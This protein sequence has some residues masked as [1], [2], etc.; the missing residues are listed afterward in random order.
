M[1]ATEAILVIALCLAVV[2]AVGVRVALSL[3]DIGISLDRIADAL[4]GG[5]QAKACGSPRIPN[6]AGGQD[7]AAFAAGKAEGEGGA[8]AT[9]SEIAAVIATAARY[10]TQTPGRK[11][12]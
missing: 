4:E 3:K 5:A 2:A 6:A 8:F 11:D 9:E 10:A 12:S 7:A 1:I